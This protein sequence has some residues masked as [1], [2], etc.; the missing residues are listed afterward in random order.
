MHVNIMAK[1]KK[2]LFELEVPYFAI[3]RKRNDLGSRD[4]CFCSFSSFGILSG[5]EERFWILREMKKEQLT[6]PM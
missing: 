4:F 1:Q 5:F 3:R 2:N 6:P